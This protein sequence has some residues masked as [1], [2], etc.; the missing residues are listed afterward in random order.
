MKLMWLEIPLATAMAVGVV[1][2]MRAIRLNVSPGLT[3]YSATLSADAA[4][5]SDADSMKAASSAIK[6]RLRMA[7]SL[8]R[9]NAISDRH[10]P[11]WQN[12]VKR[13]QCPRHEG[14]V[15]RALR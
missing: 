8:A 9:Q 4:A 3:M 5:I 10:M 7:S 14:I 15:A 12:D 13:F 11:L 2:Y 1:L 6:M